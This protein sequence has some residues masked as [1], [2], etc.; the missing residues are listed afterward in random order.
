MSLDD[1]HRRYQQQAGWTAGLRRFIFQRFGW[2]RLERVLEVGCGTG[3]VLAELEQGPQILGIDIDLDSLHHARQI[4]GHALLSQADVFALP[5]RDG[6]FS[7]TYCHFLLLWLSDPLA[8]LSEM[9]RV[10][11]PGGVL[12]ALAEPDYGHR[13]DYPPELAI[14]GDWQAEALHR[15]GADPE[16]GRKLRSLFASSGLE[17][18]QSGLLGGEWSGPPPQE[19]CEIEWSTLRED[20]RG[21]IPAEALDR[22]QALDSSAWQRGDRVLFVPTFY[23]LGQVPSNP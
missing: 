1:R 23:A 4:A 22:L 11:R 5:F 6:A 15:Q 12:V 17:N 7:L 13:I 18:A 10:T 2:N 14:L 3:A 8:A 21:E 9:K 20:L 16:L 19:D